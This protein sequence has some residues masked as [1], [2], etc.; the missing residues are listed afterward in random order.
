MDIF[1]AP[2]GAKYEILICIVLELYQ[3]NQFSFTCTC[4]SCE[5]LRLHH[6]KMTRITENRTIQMGITQWDDELYK[7]DQDGFMQ[8]NT[9]VYCPSIDQHQIMATYV[10]KCLT[11][12]RQN[13]MVQKKTS[14]VYNVPE[15]SWNNCPSSYF[16]LFALP[17]GHHT[18]FFIG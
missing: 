3:I 16:S 18:L 11:G 12:L 14:L 9:G 6:N 17:Y 7:Q 15:H 4:N 10:R 13:C 1:H 5:I 8:S 2:P